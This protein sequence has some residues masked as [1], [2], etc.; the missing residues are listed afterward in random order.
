MRLQPYQ[1]IALV[2]TICN[3]L[4]VATQLVL[5]ATI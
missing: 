2:V 3:L 1:V 5:L 4:V